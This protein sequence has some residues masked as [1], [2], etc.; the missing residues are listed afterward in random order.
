MYICYELQCSPVNCSFN[1][2]KCLNAWTNI[3]LSFTALILSKWSTSWINDVVDYL[4]KTESKKLISKDIYDKHL[5]IV[6]RC[7][8]IIYSFV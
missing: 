3:T 7:V 8:N 2:V 4:C 5:T 1:G 6:V